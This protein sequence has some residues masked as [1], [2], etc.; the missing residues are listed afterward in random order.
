QNLNQSNHW[1]Q[2]VASQ[3]EH[4][5][6]RQQQDLQQQLM[7]ALQPEIEKVI[8]EQLAAVPDSTA[9]A[10][11]TL[12]QALAQLQLVQ[13]QMVKRQRM[14]NALLMVALAAGVLALLQINLF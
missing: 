12:Q 10:L 6:T 13:D 1:Q 3:T 7:T 4:W 14:T 9:P 2:Q 5:L 11:E 8:A